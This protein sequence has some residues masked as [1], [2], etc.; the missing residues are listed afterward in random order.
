M[1]VDYWV[2]P[3]LAQTGI[4][5]RSGTHPGLLRKLIFILYQNQTAMS[6]EKF[7]AYI[8]M[9]RRQAQPVRFPPGGDYI[10]GD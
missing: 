10:T 6:I 4:F 5:G 8:P 1:T 7:T 2:R 9:D 3:T